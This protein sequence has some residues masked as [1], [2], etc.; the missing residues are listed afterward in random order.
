MNDLRPQG[1]TKIEVFI[2]CDYHIFQMLLNSVP[3]S[4]LEK[5]IAHF[6]AVFLYFSILLPCIKVCSFISINAIIYFSVLP[7]TST[8]KPITK[9]KIWN[10][11]S[12]LC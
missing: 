4:Q 12:I 11:G 10:Q 8:C 1:S 9:H 2:A 3:H 5:E 6:S 7:Y